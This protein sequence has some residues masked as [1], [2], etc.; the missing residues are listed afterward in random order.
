M[1]YST[2]SCPSSFSGTS[3]VTVRAG[4]LTIA[5]QGLCDPHA[6]L[7]APLHGP[8]KVCAPALHVQLPQTLMLV[9][10]EGGVE[11]GLA[12]SALQQHKLDGTQCRPGPGDG[13]W[14]IKMT[15]DGEPCVQVDAQ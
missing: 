8:H 5:C 1:S 11:V 4:R 9:L 10:R 7:G 3:G 13:G 15:R 6:P 14:V 2:M 12:P